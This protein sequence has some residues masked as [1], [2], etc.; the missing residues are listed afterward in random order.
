MNGWHP[1]PYN[2]EGYRYTGKQLSVAWPALHAGDR[3]PFP[4]ADRMLDL[5]EA[6]PVAAP[7]RFEGDLAALAQ[8]IRNAWRAFHAGEFAE[9]V[10]L[11]ADCGAL[12]HAPANKAAGVYANYLEPDQARQAACFADAAQ[13][14]E[15]AIERLPEDPNAHYFHAFNLGRYSQSV[16]VVEALRQGI[17]HKIQA[18]LAR[19]LELDP[20]HAEAHTACGM[21]HAEIIDKV[22]R[23]IGSMTYGASAER[24]IEHFERAIELTPDSPIAHIEFGNGLYLLFGDKQLDR[25]TELYLRAAEME[26]RDAMER[27]DVESALAELE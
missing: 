14:A 20:D 8:R 4:D 3:E 6:H 15:Q 9:A 12:A 22:G 23:M 1:F 10:A 21:F 18:S 2:N 7:A 27:L 13:R 24:A 17:G 26:P 11:A 19:A 16:S 5:L 25:V